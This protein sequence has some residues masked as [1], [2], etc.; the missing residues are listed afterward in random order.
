MFFFL[1]RGGNA[2]VL[3]DKTTFSLLGP[4]LPSM[5]FSAG[6]SEPAFAFFFFFDT[7]L[8]TWDRGDLA[9]SLSSGPIEDARPKKERQRERLIERKCPRNDRRKRSGPRRNM[10][11]VELRM[12]GTH[13][14]PLL[15]V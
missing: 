9:R 2:N 5:D 13:L 4:A 12:T 15:R 14:S 7:V 8:P 6:S 1:P 3:C 11:R 10:A